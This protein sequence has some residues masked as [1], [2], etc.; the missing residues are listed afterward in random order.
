M[1]GYLL[2]WY[3]V[4][5]IVIQ[6]GPSEPLGLVFLSLYI[7]PKLVCDQKNMAKVEDVAPKIRVQRL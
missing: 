1:F 2:L 3:N 6:D 4:C 5:K 7:V